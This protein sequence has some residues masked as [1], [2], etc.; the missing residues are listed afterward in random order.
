MAGLHVACVVVALVCWAGAA[1]ALRLPG[2]QPRR[3]TGSP[4]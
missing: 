2:R 1:A 4:R 3:T